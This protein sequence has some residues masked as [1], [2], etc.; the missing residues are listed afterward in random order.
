[1]ASSALRK[2]IDIFKSEQPTPL[3]LGYKLR[4]MPNA[5]PDS[6]A[7]I[8]AA[9]KR[10]FVA[11]EAYQKEMEAAVGEVQEVFRGGGCTVAD[12]ASMMLVE[13][14]KSIE[15]HKEQAWRAW[16]GLDHGLEAMRHYLGLIVDRQSGEVRS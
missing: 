13:I 6:S 2:V 7:Q 12:R 5:G 3:P 8:V 10:L 9:K 16:V 11:Y 14:E 15:C 1:M 4:R